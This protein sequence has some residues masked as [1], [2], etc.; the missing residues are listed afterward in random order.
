[1]RRSTYPGLNCNELY[2]IDLHHLSIALEQSPFGFDTFPSL[3]A[4]NLSTEIADY[5]KAIIND[6]RFRPTHRRCRGH[7]AYRTRDITA[8]A[9]TI[10][11]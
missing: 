1:V 4:G 10:T 9:E 5:R 6:A 7:R 2:S 3:Y 11:K 8:K